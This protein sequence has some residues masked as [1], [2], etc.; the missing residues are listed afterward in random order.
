MKFELPGSK[1][2]YPPPKPYKIKHV[3]LELE[4]DFEAKKII[5]KEHITI[6]AVAE[7]LELLTLDAAELNIKNVKS[8]GNLDFRQI[9]DKLHVY[10]DPISEGSEM[11][12]EINYEAKPR[13]GFYFIKPDEAY[14]NKSIQAWTQGEA[15]DSKYWFVCFD[16]PDMKF[17]SEII[18]KVPREFMAISN[19]KLIEVEEKDDKKIYQWLE[20]HEH[21]AYLTSV[22]IGDFAKM[23]EEYNGIKLEYYV[24]KDKEELAM[25]S[26]NHTRDML[27]FFEEYTGVKYPYEKYAQVVVEDF[28]YG[29]MENINATTLTMDTIHDRK[30][31]IDFTSDHLVSH[32]LA[33]QWFGDLV[34]CR[35]WQHLWLNE[36]FAT[37][38]E[39][40]YWK[41]SRGKDEFNY[42]MLQTAEEYFEEASKRYKRPIVT[43]VYKNPDDLFDRHT[44]EK[45]ACVLHMLRTRIG[46]KNFR[47]AIKT[48]LERYKFSNAETDDF[49][50]CV[51][52]YGFSLQQFFDQWLRTA[53]HPELRVELIYTANVA[54]IKVTQLQED[55]IFKFPL[56]IRVVTQ[57]DEIFN[58]RV[59]VEEKEHSFTIPLKKEE[60]IESHEFVTYPPSRPEEEIAYLSI[61]PDNK[62]LKR[63]ELKLPK[64]MLITLLKKG[65]TVEK[66]Y[67]ANSL[68][69]HSS[70]DV[71]KA[72]KDT[73]LDEDIFWGVS[74][75]CARA[76]SK[77][78]TE[79]AYNALLEGLSIKH[80]K[81]RRAIVRALGE[82]RKKD[83]IDKLLPLLN[84]DESY[85]VQAEAALS[86]GKT[87]A[88]EALEHLI[89]ALNIRSF[90]E[91]IASNAIHGIAEI[92]ERLDIILEKS[93]YGE[94]HRVREA[95]TLALAKYADDD[96][97]YNRLLELLRDKWFKVRINAIKAI[98]EAKLDKALGA[99]E[100][101]ATKDL[102]PRVRRVAEEAIISIREYMKKPKEISKLEEE[103]DKLKIMNKEL[104]QRLDRLESRH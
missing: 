67:A 38:F 61:D 55:N 101:V 29:G 78:K 69:E 73:M 96:K 56:D 18:V 47:K 65:N 80:P 26:F 20:E 99:L 63:L 93:R 84:N 10:I 28:I 2:N 1:A 90:N 89:N 34:T 94:H 88:K 95:A 22:A 81:A 92:K 13:R 14:K 17:T 40:L 6:E 51:E 31:C 77:I 43:N 54:T 12:L 23:E 35:D 59:E 8:N 72:L 103:L 39:A 53:G 19:G 32:E 66:I 37:Y 21:P 83:S 44:Y 64:Q 102:E 60:E 33:H 36:A 98:E 11:T 15:T 87:R 48:Y 42:Y 30:A 79:E 68:A 104:V 74:A 50:R 49:R 7:R 91:V 41:K 4:P 5:C 85:F 24:P 71:I 100:E 27:E 57:N 75:E 45:G 82:F 16:H 52:E 76:L 97:A 86:I 25:L 70:D 9:D 46:D 3:K 58:Y 62:L